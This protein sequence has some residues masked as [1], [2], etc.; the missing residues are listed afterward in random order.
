MKYKLGDVAYSLR[1]M[2]IDDLWELVDEDK[3]F[4]I[5]DHM[6]IVVENQRIHT[7]Q[8]RRDIQGFRCA[9][10]KR[11]SGGIHIDLIHVNLGAGVTVDAPLGFYN[12][13]VESPGGS[14][15]VK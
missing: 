8:R 4:E 1:K 2:T 9:T 10:T 3:I 5:P 14:V 6:Y 13:V 11:K 7:V 15:A 12:K